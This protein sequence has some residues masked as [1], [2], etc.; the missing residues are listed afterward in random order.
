MV[1]VFI[2]LGSNLDDRIAMLEQAAAKLGAHYAN[3]VVASSPYY[4]SPALLPMEA[5]QEW[6]IP[7][8]NQVLELHTSLRPDALLRLVK[9]VEVELGR[10]DRGRWG[11]REIDIDILAYEDVVLSNESLTL[12]H[13][14]MLARDFVL[15][16]WRDIAPGWRYPVEGVMNGI[17]VGELA[18]GLLSVTARPHF[19][20]AA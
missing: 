16:P 13:P 12:P 8:I 2:G 7:F 14:E 5:P 19:Q 10:Q 3:K 15:L 17:T 20:E 4:E 1:Q 18:E 9:R 6:D 11:P